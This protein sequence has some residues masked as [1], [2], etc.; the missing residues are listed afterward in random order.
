[1]VIAVKPS[2]IPGLI[3]HQSGNY[4]NS[5]SAFEIL[6]A[7]SYSIVYEIASQSQVD[8]DDPW[9]TLILAI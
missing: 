5:T 1:M 4:S 9:K 3:T 7:R 8:H 2:Q 6:N